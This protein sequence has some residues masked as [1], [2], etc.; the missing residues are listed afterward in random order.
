MANED[1]SASR[2][3]R[4][5]RLPAVDVLRAAAI[6]WVVVFHISA[7]VGD[8]GALDEYYTAVPDALGDGDAAG[9]F[10][11]LWA[12]FVRLG[13]QGVP[14][15]MAA[16]GFVLTYGTARD[17]G[18]IAIPGWYMRR[19]R[20]LMAPYYLAFALTM[21]VVLLLALV[22]YL[23]AGTSFTHELTRTTRVGEGLYGMSW[24]LFLAGLTFVP[25]GFDAQWLFAPSPSLWFVLV[26]A[27]FYL[28]YPLLYR[29]LERTGA[30]LFLLIALAVTLLSRIPI[31][32]EHDGFG[33][34]FNWWL[35]V[36][37]L[38]FN[39]F[40]FA[41]GMAGGWTYARDPAVVRRY[42]AGAFNASMLVY[43][44]LIL[45]TI[46]DLA[47]G[48]IGWIG[49]FAAPLAVL[50]LTL[51]V[52]PFVFN[53]SEARPRQAL[54]AAFAGL[55]AMS[56]SILIASDPLR[57][58]IGTLH[59]MDAHVAVWAAFWLAYV[60]VLYGLAR[61]VEAVSR[62]LIAGPPARD[63]ALPAPLGDAP[64]PRTAG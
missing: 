11:A 59:E 20:A 17:G 45:H 49:I 55:G 54:V 43:V 13:Y 60:P 6:L 12:L 10:D 22:R 26:F 42:T 18:R 61:A 62:W 4:G 46:G 5:G 25:R 21:G 56:Y 41:L 32:L 14:L 31:V 16:S 44:G 64:E 29:A 53:A 35:D 37:W 2:A 8:F 15:F 58:V 50:G 51:I 34:L 3:S 39:L 28:A 36:S 27:Q 7:D 1:G 24:Q 19:L 47:Q 33:L 48:R 23:D 38:P 57:F 63:A 9:F 30:G 40:T 52:T